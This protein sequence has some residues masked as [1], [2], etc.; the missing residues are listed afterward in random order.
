MSVIAGQVGRMGPNLPAR[1]RMSVRRP[2]QETLRTLMGVVG[3]GGF[4]CSPMSDELQG[5][6]AGLAT[7]R[8][9]EIEGVLY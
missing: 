7:F 5:D 8:V 3:L 4:R 1:L 2:A 6:G 9:F